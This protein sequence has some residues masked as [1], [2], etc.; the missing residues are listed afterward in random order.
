MN[1]VWIL[2]ESGMVL[3]HACKDGKIDAHLF[4]GFLSAVNT[5]AMHLDDDGIGSMELGS[6]R[7]SIIKDGGV[8]FVGLHDRKVKEKRVA[9]EMQA[10]ARSFLSTYPVEAITSWNGS[11]AVFAGFGKVVGIAP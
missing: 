11:A 9:A 7:L 5:I 4:A 1:G 8:M 10:L 6:S 2:T 3:Y